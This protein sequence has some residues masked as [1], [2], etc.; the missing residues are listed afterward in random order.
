MRTIERLRRSA[1]LLARLGCISIGTV[2]FIVGSLALLALSGRLIEAADEDRM[3]QI[4]L[5]LPAGP[6]VI[7]TVIAGMT[8]YVVWRAIEVVADPYG[9]GRNWSGL[10]KRTAVALG[11]L[12]YGLLAFS[13]ARIVLAS[14]TTVGA[15]GRDVAEQEQQAFVADVLSWPAGGWVVAAAGLVLLVVGVAQFVLI[16]RRDYATEVDFECAA[17]PMRDVINVLA[18]YGYAARGVILTVLGYFLLKA[19]F[20]HDADAAGDTDTAFDFIGG[21]PVGDTAFLLVA[22]GTVAY[23]IFMYLNACYYRFGDRAD[24]ALAQRPSAYP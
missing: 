10:G 5:R 3:I 23:G 4:V 21:G 6:L 2:Y 18:M 19:A 9:F 15:A 22:L 7:W 20:T 12:G 8:A 24:D 1:R 11:A 14:G 16:V 13:A 17:A